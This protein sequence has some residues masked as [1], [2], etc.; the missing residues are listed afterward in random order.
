MA[1]DKPI[2]VRNPGRA[3]DL[4]KLY[5]DPTNAVKLFD[6]K[7]NGLTPVKGFDT[8]PGQLPFDK[9][10]ARGYIREMETIT[11]RPI[12]THQR[13]LLKQELQGKNFLELPQTEKL[14]HRDLFRS[15]KNTLI[16]E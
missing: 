3:L 15:Q 14:G 4:P 11:G 7:Q 6:V 9:F 8:S 16:K 10:L 13:L 5:L 1:G 2:I 12:P